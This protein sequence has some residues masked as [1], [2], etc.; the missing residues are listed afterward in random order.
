MNAG[1][2]RRKAS[3]TALCVPLDAV[4]SITTTASDK[5]AIVLLRRMKF[6]LKTGDTPN[7]RV[8]R[9]PVPPHFCP[10]KAFTA[11][12]ALNCSSKSPNLSCKNPSF[13]P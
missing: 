1:F 13:E 7:K 11:Q 3:R 9:H 5:R 4:A 6:P 10:E 8:F 12:K 2:F